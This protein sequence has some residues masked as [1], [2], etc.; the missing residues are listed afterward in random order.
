MALCAEVGVAFALRIVLPDGFDGQMLSVMMDKLHTYEPSRAAAEGESK[1]ARLASIFEKD[2]HKEYPML[3][4]DDV[5]QEYN[6]EGRFMKE[7]EMAATKI[8]DKDHG[9]SAILQTSFGKGEPSFAMYLVHKES[10]VTPE[11]V[12]Y[13][14]IRIPCEWNMGLDFT[15]IPIDKVDAAETEEHFERLCRAFGLDK[16]GNAGWKIIANVGQKSHAFW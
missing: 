11:D 6:F 13:E 5:V 10:M 9:V 8:L 14:E 3:K 4:Y 15:D 16:N 12:Q 2:P 1:K 7:F